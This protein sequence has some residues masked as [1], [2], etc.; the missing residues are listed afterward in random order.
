MHCQRYQSSFYI[1]LFLMGGFMTCFLV[2]YDDKTVYLESPTFVLVDSV[3][4]SLPTM[5]YNTDALPPSDLS[6]LID[7]TDFKFTMNH[8]PCNESAVSPF[9]LVLVHS[10]PQH[11][12]E[13][14]TIRSTWGRYNESVKLIFMLGSTNSSTLQRRIVDEDNAWKDIVQ[15]NFYDTYRNLT[16]KHVMALKWTTYFCMSAKYILKA[17]DDIFVN[18][19]YLLK[20]LERDFSPYGARK[21]ILCSQYSKSSVKRSYRSKWRVSPLE[22]PRK[23]YPPYC[24]G[25][26]IIYSSDVAFNLYKKAQ[27]STYFW[28]DDVHVTGT[29]AY[30]LHLTQTPLGGLVLT[31]KQLNLVLHGNLN[32]V[33]FLFGPPDL[34]SLKIERLWKLVSEYSELLPSSKQN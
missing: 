4:E 32:S 26:G 18:T 33:E 11:V 12:A 17:D 15:G 2:F 28:I 31:E 10:A 21:L 27:E 23:I 34:S 29:L 3:N 9:L 6:R 14:N 7:L 22:Y 19:P 13:R 20:F 24:A 30:Q 5:L 1:L 16:Y 8:F 25:F